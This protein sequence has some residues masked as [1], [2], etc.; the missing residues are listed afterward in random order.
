MKE[1]VILQ[2]K[3][4][5]YR[6]KNKIAPRMEPSLR[7]HMKEITHPVRPLEKMFG[8]IQYSFKIATDPFQEL[9]KKMGVFTSSHT[10]PT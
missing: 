2:M 3:V 4:D 9:M 5:E 10:N 6:R 7:F 1:M 8:K